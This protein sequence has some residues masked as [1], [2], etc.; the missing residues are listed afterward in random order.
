VKVV[1]RIAKKPKLSRSHINWSSLKKNFP[2]AGPF[3]GDS[4][5]VEHLEYM[6]NGQGHLGVG[7]DEHIK[8]M[9]PAPS[10]SKSI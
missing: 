6:Y 9:W 3:R 4:T 8:K 5:V 2:M 7:V 10:R 1:E